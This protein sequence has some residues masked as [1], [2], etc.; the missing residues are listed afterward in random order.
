VEI[1]NSIIFD[2]T[3]IPHYNYI[4]DSVIGSNCNF[5]AGTKIANLRHDHGIVKVAGIAT[6]RKKFGAVIGDDVLFGINCSIN[7]GSSIGS[8]SRIAPHTLVSGNLENNTVV[9]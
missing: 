3:K 9:Q 2:G 4:G 5:G 8:G 1:K 6:A 7:T